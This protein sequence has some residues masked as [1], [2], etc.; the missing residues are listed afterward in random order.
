ML[1]VYA[2]M[3]DKQEEDEEMVEKHDHTCQLM[4]HLMLMNETGLVFETKVRLLSLWGHVLETKVRL[5]SLLGHVFETGV[6]VF[7]RLRP[8]IRCC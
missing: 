2:T 6:M 8:Y 4:K 3:D 7:V 1:S 5:R